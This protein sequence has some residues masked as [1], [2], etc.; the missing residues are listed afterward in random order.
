MTTFPQ[1]RLVDYLLGMLGL[2]TAMLAFSF[3]RAEPDLWGHVQYGREALLSGLPTTATHTFT[4]ADYPWINHENLFEI[5]SAALVATLGIPGL[6]WGKCLLGLCVVG[7]AANQARRQHVS[8]FVAIAGCTVMVLGLTQS[9]PVRPQVLSYTFYAIMLS[10]LAFAFEGWQ[11]RWLLFPRSG[12]GSVPSPPEIKYHRFN[13]RCLWG[14]PVLMAL[15][16]NSHGGFLAGLL[17]YLVYLLV[18][19]VEAFCSARKDSYGMLRRLGLMCFVAVL[20]TFLNPYGL[21]LHTWIADAM[22]VQRPEITEWQAAHIGD[23]TFPILMLLTLLTGAGLIFGGRSL[24]AAEFS[25][26]L[27]TGIQAFMH[28]R[29]LPFFAI[30]IGF[31]MPRHWEGAWQ[32]L[33]RSRES[34]PHSSCFWMNRILDSLQAHGGCL[35]VARNMVLFTA[36]L[37]LASFVGRRLSCL[38]VE[39]SDYPVAAVDYMDRHRLQGRVVVTYNWAQYLLAAFANEQHGSYG[40]TVAFDG[41]LD[42]C[43]PAEIIDEHFDFILGNDPPM[44]RFRD[45]DSPHATADGVLNRG[46]PTLVLISRY[47]PHAMNVMQKHRADW[48]LLYQDELAQLWGRREIYDEEISAEHLPVHHREIS[49][50]PQ[51]GQIPWPAIN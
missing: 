42:T 17:L 40:S 25:M 6:L 14:M 36:C 18:R 21:H 4:A 10:L 30:T 26:L 45:P 44:K 11:G 24:D 13:I 49:D 7:L 20:A 27:L 50:R 39:K 16:T 15:W 23:E 48:V 35:D 19:G 37:I 28:I 22:S 3:C 43:Y 31:T 34:T 9:W 12:Q 51:A 32:R 47:Q 1:I 41:R 2:L 29:H 8:P 38:A 5:I 46:S 33:Q